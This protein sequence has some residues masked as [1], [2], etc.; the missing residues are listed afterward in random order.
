MQQIMGE[1]QVVINRQLESTKQK[2]QDLR[3]ETDKW[4]KHCEFLEKLQLSLSKGLTFSLVQLVSQK[5]SVGQAELLTPD[6]IST[7]EKI[8]KIASEESI[9][10][11]NKFPI[12][13][14]EA[15][16]SKGIVFD[17]DSRFPRYNFYNGFLRLDVIESKGL[18]RLSCTEGILGEVPAD[19][20]LIIELIL[21]Q[22]KRLFERPF[23]PERF[24]KKI[25]N[26]YLAIIK[27]ENA[28]DGSSIHIR[29]ITSRLGHNEKG[30]KNDEFTVDILK[31]LKSKCVDIHGKRLSLQQTKDT[32]KGLFIP[33]EFGGYVGFVQFTES[34]SKE[35]R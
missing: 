3:V 33:G 15:C 20:E 31:L 1:S 4:K 5:E 6:L 35:G 23:N 22:F 9:S 14:E 21:G 26:Q 8:K 32:A 13:F 7:L 2:V 16:K 27:K 17:W 25:R 28:T 11:M 19:I 34:N 24:L 18:A 29:K 30:F 10:K 12:L